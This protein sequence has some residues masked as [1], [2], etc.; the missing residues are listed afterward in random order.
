MGKLA[1][2]ELDMHVSPMGFL[3]LAYAIWSGIGTVGTVIIGML[4]WQEKLDAWRVLGIVLILLG[5]VVVNF[6]SSGDAHAQ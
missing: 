6:F 2:K 1:I 4:L 3:M 5:V